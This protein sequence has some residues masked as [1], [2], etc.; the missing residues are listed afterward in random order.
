MDS[1]H[2]NN[3][4]VCLFYHV[5]CALMIS[6]DDSYTIPVIGIIHQDKQFNNHREH[7]HI[8]GRFTSSKNVYHNGVFESGKT[9]NIIPVDGRN[10]SGFF[11]K[12]IVIKKLKCK[13]KITGIIPPAR[14]TDKHS[15]WKWY[16]SYVGKS[17]K[18]RR[19]PHLGT[20][21]MEVEGKLV[22]PLHNLHGNVKTE[23]IIAI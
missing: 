2:L 9:N 13:R 15:Y 6:D 8:D 4:E 18:G 12:E 22:C 16:D 14:Y 17:C 10:S 3:P 5:A 7:L 19:C 21:M 11:F 1:H 20:S 23:T